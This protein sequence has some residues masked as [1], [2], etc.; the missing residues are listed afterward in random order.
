MHAALWFESVY[1][2]QS[3]MSSVMPAHSTRKT[4]YSDDVLAL[5]SKL[6]HA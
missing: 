4:I 5:T 3:P 2:L 1:V 6:G